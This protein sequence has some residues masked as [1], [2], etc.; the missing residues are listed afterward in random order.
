VRDA[1]K[2]WLLRHLVLHRRLDKNVSSATAAPVPPSVYP[3][4]PERNQEGREL[5]WKDSKRPGEGRDRTS[6]KSRVASAR[7]C[8]VR[9]LSLRWHWAGTVGCG[10]G[11]L[12]T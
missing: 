10:S 9:T 8:P 5:Q 4:A 6:E 11:R 2:P 3:G 7:T 12:D 1:F